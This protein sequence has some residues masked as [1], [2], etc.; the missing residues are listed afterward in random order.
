MFWQR[1]IFEGMSTH[2]GCRSL[3]AKLLQ[4][5]KY[6]EVRGFIRAKVRKA[7]WECILDEDTK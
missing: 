7:R 2:V 3:S 1:V 4:S 5:A 6:A